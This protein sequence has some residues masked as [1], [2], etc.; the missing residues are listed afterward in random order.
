MHS[1]RTTPGGDTAPLKGRV[2]AGPLEPG[3]DEDWHAVPHRS[4]PRGL[5]SRA[6]E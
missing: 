3:D 5:G 6:P 1:R 4:G 2:V